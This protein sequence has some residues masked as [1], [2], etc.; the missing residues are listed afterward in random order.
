MS[1]LCPMESRVADE[2]PEENGWR[3]FLAGRAGA[4]GGRTAHGWRTASGVRTTANGLRTAGRGC[5]IGGMSDDT[6]QVER[7]WHWEFLGHN[8][9]PDDAEAFRTG[10]AVIVIGY[11]NEAD[12]EVAVRT[13]VPRRTYRLH[14]VWECA[15]CGFQSE[16]AQAMRRIAD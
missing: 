15:S 4:A 11:D 10:T 14:R 16:L 9:E 13:I 5:R 1:L 12:A 2:R 7:H 3:K 6:P 8:G